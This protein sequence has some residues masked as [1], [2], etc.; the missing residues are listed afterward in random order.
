[1]KDK[2]NVSSLENHILYKKKGKVVTPLN[3]SLGDKLRL[4]SWTKERMPEYL[5]LALILISYGRT[6]GFEV[7]G[8]ILLKI[9][10]EIPELTHPKLSRIFKLSVEKQIIVYKIIC[11]YIDLRIL[12]PLTIIY[13]YSEYQVFNSFINTTEIPFKT[14][15]EVLEKC[16]EAF[17]P[18][19]SNDATDLRF[20]ALSL[21][22]FGK[23]INLPKGMQTTINAFTNYTNTEHDEEI[24]REY[25]P[26][27]RSLEGMDFDQKDDTFLTYFWKEIGKM[28]DCKLFYLDYSKNGFNFEKYFKTVESILDYLIIT[29]KLESLANHKFDVLIGSLTFA[30]KVFKE[31]VEKDLGNSIHGRLGIRLLLEIYIISKYLIITSKEKNNIWEEY[32]LYGI[33]KYK[34]VLLKARKTELDKETHF[35]SIVVDAIVNEIKWEEFIDI[36]LKYFD[37]LG[38]REKSHIV[39]EKQLYDI[40]YDYDSSFAHGLW[41]AIRESS[42]LLCDSASHQYHC[43]P[44]I[45]GNQKLPDVLN[46]SKVIMDKIV[47][48]ISTEFDIPEDLLKLLGMENDK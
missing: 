18:S 42:M 37:N 36:D 44:D 12:S 27:I 38:I 31:I 8:K 4:N 6:K 23:K 28:T 3:D 5:W 15:K 33:S 39:G 21:L 30:K 26:T 43:I 35:K 40:Y 17:S 47:S 14:R 7:T 34:L 22:L 1:M 20:L 29:Q 19:Q 9:S 13:R 48:L 11:S 41:G 25:R 10:K 32:K 45:Y 46:D 2:K 16:I 24:M